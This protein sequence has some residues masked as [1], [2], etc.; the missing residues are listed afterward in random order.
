[1]PHLRKYVNSHIAYLLTYWRRL[2]PRTLGFMRERVC[3]EQSS[4]HKATRFPRN[5]P[6]FGGII[7][8]VALLLLYVDA[9]GDEKGSI[10]S[11]HSFHILQ[12]SWSP[13]GR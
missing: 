5:T 10:H 2:I 8:D 1:M 11:T 3:G 12:S 6:W 4:P 7:M 13:M 9:E